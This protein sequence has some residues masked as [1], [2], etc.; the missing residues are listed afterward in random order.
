MDFLRFSCNKIDLLVRL[1]KVQEC[2][3]LSQQSVFKEAEV[4]K[5]QK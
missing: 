2:V 3:I 1:V 5:K 4:K